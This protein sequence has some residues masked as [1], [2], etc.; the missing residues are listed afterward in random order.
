MRDSYVSLELVNHHLRFTGRFSGRQVEQEEDRWLDVH[1]LEFGHASLCVDT[2][3]FPA[4]RYSHLHRH[5]GGRICDRS[6]AR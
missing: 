2:K 6:V 3:L 1:R 5:W 4:L